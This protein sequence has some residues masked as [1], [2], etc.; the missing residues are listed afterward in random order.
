[1]G[2]HPSE[3]AIGIARAARTCIEHVER[4]RWAAQ[5]ALPCMVALVDQ[6][7]KADDTRDN[8]WVFDDRTDWASPS[9]IVRLA[10]LARQCLAAPRPWLHL[11]RGMSRGRLAALTVRSGARGI[12]LNDIA[13]PA[14]VMARHLPAW[15][16]SGPH[17]TAFDPACGEEAKA[18][19]VGALDELY[20]QGAA[21][22]VYMDLQGGPGEALACDRSDA[23]RGMYRIYD[24]ID[25]PPAVHLL[26]AGPMLRE[27][28]AAAAQLLA[29]WGI[30]AQAWSCPSYTRLARDAA[31]STAGRVKGLCH[32]HACLGSA[33]TPV[34]AVTAYAQYVA[35]QLKPHL[36]AGFIA[37]GSDSLALGQPL[38][39]DWIV[40]AALQ[41]LVRNGT[42]YPE[43]LSRAWSRYQLA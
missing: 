17:C 16:R 40:V 24:V 6:L 5:A 33:H 2:R 12:I 25:R 36:A 43:V 42:L 37:L 1:M 39:R 9:H 13:R 41:A 26:G 19:L 3:S 31:A 27:V 14:G 8:V 10:E 32:L 11:A 4:S 20:V 28:R 7:R 38:N 23:Y 15:S 30:I 29:D 18:I 21:G 35:A 34:V 22:F